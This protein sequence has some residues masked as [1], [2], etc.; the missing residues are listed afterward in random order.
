MENHAWEWDLLDAGEAK[1]IAKGEAKATKRL[2]ELL[3]ALK[4]EGKTD[5]FLQAIEDPTL[6]ERL[7]AEYN[8]Q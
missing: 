7:F 2:A 8:I 6:C 3:S 4:K 5:L 1:G